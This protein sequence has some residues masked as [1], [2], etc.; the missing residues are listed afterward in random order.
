MS[1]NYTDD[2]EKV[3]ENIR[4]NSILLYKEHQKRYLYLKDT[5][6]YYKLPLI[7][8]SSLSSIISV[9]QQ[10]IPQDTITILNSSLSFICS[11]IGATELFMGI[12]SQMVL[13]L[14]TSKDYHILAMDI[15]KCLSL[16]PENRSS[17]GRAYLEQCY[18]TYTKLIEN[19]CIVRR[20]IEDKLCLIEKDIPK[21]CDEESKVSSQ[22]LTI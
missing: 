8:V 1:N 18:G 17:E 12:S 3:L 6:K 20:K 11:I 4:I 7:F 9:S 5:L 10:F 22:E 21:D 2:I 15:Y 13:E 14:S 16:K 19:S